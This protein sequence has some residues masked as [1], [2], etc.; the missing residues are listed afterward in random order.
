M[1]RCAAARIKDLGFFRM[2][3]GTAV[4]AFLAVV[5]AVGMAMVMTAPAYA[6]TTYRYLTVNDDGITWYMSNCNNRDNTCTLTR[7]PAYYGEFSFQNEYYYNGGNYYQMV[8]KSTG[9]CITAPLTVGDNVTQASCSESA[10]QWWN[11]DGPAMR[12][13][14]LDYAEYGDSSESCLSAVA[15]APQDSTMVYY[16]ADIWWDEWA[17]P[18]V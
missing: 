1:D 5:S 6:T 15:A 3:I 2:R 16:C 10:L 14:N 9:K 4:K 7:T 12:S 17:Q 18:V 13:T 8:N 11:Y